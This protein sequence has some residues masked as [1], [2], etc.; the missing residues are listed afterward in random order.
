MPTRPADTKCFDPVGP[1][2]GFHPQRLS[3]RDELKGSCKLML[4]Q[5]QKYRKAFACS[6]LPGQQCSHITLEVTWSDGTY[7]EANYRW[8]VAHSARATQPTMLPANQQTS[9]AP[10]SAQCCLCNDTE[11]PANPAPLL[12]RTQHQVASTYGPA[13]GMNNPF[14]LTGELTA[15]LCKQAH[16]SHHCPT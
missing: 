7:Q 4:Q 13:A 12:N 15:C 3:L 10:A 1:I 9:N 14:V 16:P 2:M 8:R 5:R 11:Q 6:A